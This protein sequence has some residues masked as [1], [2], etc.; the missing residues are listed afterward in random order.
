[1]V[2]FRKRPNDDVVVAAQLMDSQVSDARKTKRTS[3]GFLFPIQEISSEMPS[4]PPM[5]GPVV[6]ATV[7]C[8]E[9]EKFQKK[10]QR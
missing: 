6:L 3:A 8:V 9:A 1:M 5:I 7:Q 10:V 2:S 4:T